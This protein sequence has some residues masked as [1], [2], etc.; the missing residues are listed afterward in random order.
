MHTFYTDIEE[1]EYTDN[2]KVSRI[3]ST[4]IS[5][6]L[7]FGDTKPIQSSSSMEQSFFYDRNGFLTKESTILKFFNTSSIYTTHYSY[8]AIGRKKCTFSFSE[9]SDGASYYRENSYS[10]E[11]DGEY[12][13]VTEYDTFRTKKVY[14]YNEKGNIST[15]K[16]YEIR[17]I[18]GK[19]TDYLTSITEY[20]YN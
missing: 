8:D 20:T 10:Y 15:I 17:N 6:Q 13:K 12:T 11:D 3:Y 18:D 2:G 1:Y 7:L 16:L 5:R 19:N 4:S 9:D 14:S